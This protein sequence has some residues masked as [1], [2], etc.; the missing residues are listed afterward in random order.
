MS[1]IEAPQ[2]A[3]FRRLVADHMAAMGW[4]MHEDDEGAVMIKV[5]GLFDAVITA[6][7]QV[8][9]GLPPRDEEDAAEEEE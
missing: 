3:E 2:L 8:V 6:T 5:D 4:P 9:T 1:R 7:L